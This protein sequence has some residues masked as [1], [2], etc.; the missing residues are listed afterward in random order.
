M[1][2]QITG[3]R[4][5]EAIEEQ[6]IVTHRLA[7]M[8]AQEMEDKSS[9]YVMIIPQLL[10]GLAFLSFFSPFYFSLSSYVCSLTS[11]S[12][13]LSAPSSAPFWS[14]SLGGEVGVILM[15]CLWLRTLQPLLLCALPWCEYP[16]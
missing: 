7:A 2:F 13:H 10:G 8:S 1:I 3:S 16:Y 15:S 6:K 4:E 11:G 9:I 12:H 5:I 14:L